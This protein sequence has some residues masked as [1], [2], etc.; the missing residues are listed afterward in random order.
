MLLRPCFA[1][2]R[3]F[4][5]LARRVVPAHLSGAAAIACWNEVAATHPLLAAVQLVLGDNS[6]A[7]RFA[8]YL[9]PS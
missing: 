6:V 8:R 3:V 9:A 4:A 7:G 2:R 1:L 5:T